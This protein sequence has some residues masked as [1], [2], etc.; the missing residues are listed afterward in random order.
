LHK[1]DSHIEGHTH[2]S[3]TCRL[4]NHSINFNEF[5]MNIIFVRISNYYFSK[6]VKVKFLS[7]NIL[8]RRKRDV[9]V[10]LHAFFY[11]S[12]SQARQW[13]SRRA[14]PINLRLLSQS[15]SYFKTGDLP[16]ICSSWWKVRWDS[17]PVFFFQLN[18]YRSPY[19]T[20]L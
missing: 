20:C 14:N 17:R 6:L 8:L 5:K 3:A 7:S 10:Y 16:P 15:Q 9:K 12:I 19:V 11:L 1:M 4:Q 13:L 2:P 18:T